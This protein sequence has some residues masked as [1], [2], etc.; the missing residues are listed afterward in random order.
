MIHKHYKIHEIA[1]AK[2]VSWLSLSSHKKPCSLSVKRWNPWLRDYLQVNITSRLRN[3]DKKKKNV[4]VCACT[5]IDRR[6]SHHVPNEGHLILLVFTS[7]GVLFYLFSTSH[8]KVS[9]LRKGDREEMPSFVHLLLE[10]GHVSHVPNEGHLILLVFTSGGVLFY[11]FSTSHSK[12][13]GGY[14]V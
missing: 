4:I 1:N 6:W 2:V 12:L 5:C 7:G 10:G 3:W 8:S 14:V 13:S 11:V 9:G